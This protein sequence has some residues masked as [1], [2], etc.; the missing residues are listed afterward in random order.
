[1]LLAPQLL[2]LAGA[3]ALACHGGVRQ[4]LLPRA[5]TPRAP[6]PH[7]AAPPPTCIAD[8]PLARMLVRRCR[9]SPLRR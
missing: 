8:A 6:L 1:M 3:S 5:A 2:A 9:A 7:A 4:H